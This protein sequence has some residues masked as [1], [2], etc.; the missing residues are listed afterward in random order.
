MSS[1]LLVSYVAL[2]LLV[3]FQTLVL[4]ALTQS[5]YKARTPYRQFAA[6]D[7]DRVGTKASDFTATDINGAIVDSSDYKAQKR[8]LVFVSP[9]CSTCS[10]TLTEMHAL[11]SKADGNVIVVCRGSHDECRELA[12]TH[13]VSAP[14]I[15]DED[16]VV[17][18]K[19][20]V[21]SVPVAVIVDEKD[22]ITSYGYPLRSDEEEE[23]IRR[24]S[25]VGASRGSEAP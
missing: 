18:Q 7:L 14:T 19:F 5:V 15:A 25:L 20:A 16:S 24:G 4:I 1:A 21:T 11:E 2:W 12:R 17:S 22:T 23:A 13:D 9:H 6:D 10:L 3:G 8:A